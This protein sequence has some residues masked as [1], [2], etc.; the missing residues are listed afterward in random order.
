MNASNLNVRLQNYLF[1]GTGIALIAIVLLPALRT[2]VEFVLPQ[3]LIVT[4]ISIAPHILRT[5][6]WSPTLR[7]FLSFSLGA[8]VPLWIALLVS[9]EIWAISIIAIIGTVIAA[10][11]AMWQLYSTIRASTFQKLA[12]VVLSQSRQLRSTITILRRVTFSF[13]KSILMIKG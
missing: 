1:C 13:F 3:L 5:T 10:A 8:A 4:T 7:N 6:L 2:N 12:P 9:A 11:V